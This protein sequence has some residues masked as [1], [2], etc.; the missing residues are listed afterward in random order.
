MPQSFAFQTPQA[1]DSLELVAEALNCPNNKNTFY[2]HGLP[3]R[4]ILS[5]GR[6]YQVFGWVKGNHPQPGALGWATGGLGNLHGQSPLFLP[7]NPTPVL[8]SKLSSYFPGTGG[9]KALCQTIRKSAS[10]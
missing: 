10:K 3:L 1:L 9:R 7:K 4:L 2:L 8:P 5:G 6:S